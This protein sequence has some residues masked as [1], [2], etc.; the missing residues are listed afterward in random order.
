MQAVPSCGVQIHNTN[1]LSSETNV[2]YQN[3][4][5]TSMLFGKTSAT[6]QDSDNNIVCYLV[7]LM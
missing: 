1:M 5:N 3:T 6:Y 4:D 2:I 7:R